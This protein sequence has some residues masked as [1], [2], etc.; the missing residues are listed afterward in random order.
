MVFALFCRQKTK[1]ENSVSFLFCMN[2]GY[3]EKQRNN[4]ANKQ[5]NVFFFSK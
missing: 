5:E 2:H 1:E 4:K 3:T